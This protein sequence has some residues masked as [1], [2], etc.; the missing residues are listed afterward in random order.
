M[1]Q[2]SSA[3]VINREQPQGHYLVVTYFDGKIQWVKWCRTW[4]G[5]RKSK[6][7]SE[8]YGELHA[9]VAA[10]NK[11]LPNVWL[12]VSVENQATADERISLL[13][14]TPAAIRW[15]SFEPMLGLI[16]L[17]PRPQRDMCLLEHP[18]DGQCLR[19]GLDWYEEARCLVRTGATEAGSLN[20]LLVDSLQAR[21][22][23]LRRAQID[24]EFV[25]MKHDAK[26]RKL[27][28]TI[29]DEFASND[30][31]TLQVAEG[32]QQ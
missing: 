22:R 13:L 9:K 24:A 14:Q 31:Q 11:P 8:K 27:A 28:Q 19:R 25:D 20:D 29:A 21:L 17:K 2:A 18:H 23:Q 4:R 1:S 12:G 32:E 6:R 10:L 30:R 3:P 7:N 26:Y 15:M 5:A 16:D